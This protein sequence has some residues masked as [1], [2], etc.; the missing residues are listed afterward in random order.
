LL[1]GVVAAAVISTIAAPYASAQISATDRALAETLFQEGRRLMAAKKY[2]EACPKLAESQRLDPATGTLLNL[3]V[4][5]TEEGKLASA[6]V[7]LN[8]ALTSA[9]RD[10]RADRE[11]YARERLAAIQPRL[12]HITIVVPEA[13]RVAGLQVKL[14]GSAIGAGAWGLA[15][16]VD[17]GAH[18]VVASA[19]GRR[20]WT[21]R[22]SIRATAD[23]ETV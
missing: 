5:H 8:E 19:P 15:T 23:D 17:P 4:C 10:G 11:A 22:V 18:E 13:A 20:A 3:A 6:W 7:E 9:R 1:A 16:P 12:S 14:D 21:A 2:V